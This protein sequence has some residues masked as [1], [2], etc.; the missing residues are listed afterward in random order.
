MDVFLCHTPLHVLIAALVAFDR[1]VEAHGRLFFVVE[2]TPGLHRLAQ[3][4]LRGPSSSF[5]L[6]PGTASTTDSKT[7]RA[8]QNVNART[9][10]RTLNGKMVEHAYIFFDQRAEGQALLRA[11]F[12]RQATICLLEDGISS[13]TVA[14]P[15]SHPILRLMRNKLRHSIHWKGSKWL[16]EHPAISEVGCFYPNHLRPG[17]KK[18]SSRALPT[19][20][21]EGIVDAF[22]ATYGG[23]Q[24]LEPFGAI[25]VPHP[26]SGIS[27]EERA[28]FIERAVAF[29]TQRSVKPLLKLHPRDSETALPESIDNAKTLV[30]GKGLPIEL[31]L[32][33]EPC[34]RFVVGSRTSTLHVTKALHP[35]LG[36]YF[37]EPPEARN[38]SEWRRF[39]ADLSIEALPEAEA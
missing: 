2:D 38:S 6:L 29:C 11:H 8:L 16:G 31:L 23:R 35:E 34:A 25:V 20:I 12:G 27:R 26:H 17:L 4:L 30:A 32:Y 37:Y 1:T 7:W 13:Y 39:Y 14:S 3:T 33:V 5:S 15:F 24:Y 10:S 19:A 22:A 28:R 21:E 18:L 36:V 9:V